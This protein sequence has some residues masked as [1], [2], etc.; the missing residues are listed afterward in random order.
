M[1]FLPP[2]MFSLPLH[3][4]PMRLAEK[5]ARVKRLCYAAPTSHSRCFGGAIFVYAANSPSDR[6]H[7]HTQL[8]LGKPS[9]H[10][11]A[12]TASPSPFATAGLQQPPAHPAFARASMDC[13]R[14]RP[15]LHIFTRASMDSPRPLPP[16][17]RHVNPALRTATTAPPA[18]LQQHHLAPGGIKCPAPDATGDGFAHPAVGSY[19]SSSGSS[20]PD[21]PG[22]PVAQPPPLARKLSMQ[23]TASKSVGLDT[24]AAMNI[25]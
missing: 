16:L 8:S 25:D 18:A 17:E 14:P 9:S 23:R 12:V 11:P 6:V 20:R 21:S 1:G 2:A 7:S 13:P 3:N 24:L 19:S 4:S 22:T 10:P 5:F 15:P